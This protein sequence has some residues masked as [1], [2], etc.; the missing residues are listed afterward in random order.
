L[1]RRILWYVLFAFGLGFIQKLLIDR[2]TLFGAKPDAMLLLAVWIGRRE[3]GSIGTTSGFFIGLIMDLLHGTLGIESFA[4]TVSGFV[5]GFFSDPDDAEKIGYLVLAVGLAAFF[6]TAAR[7]LLASALQAPF[8]KWLTAAVA[9]ALF[10]ILFGFL[11]FGVSKK[12]D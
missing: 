7:E 8:W 12:L 1:Q 10:N 3:G 5:A 4:K 9:S 6:G 11:F 2:L